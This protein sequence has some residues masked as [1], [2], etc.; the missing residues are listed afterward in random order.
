MGD[1]RASFFEQED[2]EEVDIADLIAPDRREKPTREEFTNVELEAEA[3]GFVRRQPKKRRRMSPYT[4]QFGGKCRPGMKEIF[5]EIG[6]RLDLY[7]TQTLERAI[8][9][10][11]EKEELDDLVGQF[12]KLVKEKH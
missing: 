8:L 7:D 2:N 6:E 4:A 5:Q 10:L 11:L 9:A 3:L 1:T 12:E